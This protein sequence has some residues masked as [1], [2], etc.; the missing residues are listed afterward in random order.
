V[1]PV[2]L[3]LSDAAVV[4][5][6]EQADWYTTQSGP[7]LARRWEKAVSSAILRIL[8]NPFSGASCAF[9]PSELH[10]VRRSTITGF[11][12]H[13]LFY[14]FLEGELLVLRVVHGAR[15]LEPQL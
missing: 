2:R 5:I 15:D 13:L 1:K 8:K 3:A 7:A 11:P 6:L 12:K 14:R 10:N 4:D 9:R